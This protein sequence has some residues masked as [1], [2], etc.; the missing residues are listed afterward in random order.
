MTIVYAGAPSCA[1]KSTACAWQRVED[2]LAHPQTMDPD[3][4]FPRQPSPHGL[5]LQ[6]PQRIDGDPAAAPRSL[7]RGGVECGI[8]FAD[9]A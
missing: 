4:L 3:G 8:A 2:T 5:A 7:D 1:V 6:L 9:S